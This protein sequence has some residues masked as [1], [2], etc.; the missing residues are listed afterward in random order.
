MLN[1]LILWAGKGPHGFG[2]VPKH[3]AKGGHMKSYFFTWFLHGF[4]SCQFAWTCSWQDLW[5]ESRTTWRWREPWKRW[6]KMDWGWGWLMMHFSS[7]TLQCVSAGGPMPKTAS[8]SSTVRTSVCDVCWFKYGLLNCNVFSPCVFFLLG[9]MAGGATEH[10]QKMNL[11]TGKSCC[12]L[13]AWGAAG[14][15]SRNTT[16]WNCD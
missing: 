2:D 5:K 13:G 1:F 7:L 3:G 15:Q 8:Q 14:S 9:F 4:V 6:R 10:R 12:F 11:P 16:W